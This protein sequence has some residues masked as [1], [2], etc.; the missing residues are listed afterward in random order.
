MTQSDTKGLDAILLAAGR[1][2]RFGG[3]K[4]LAMLDGA[5]LVVHALRTALLAPARRVYVA[6]AD[7]AVRAAVEV[8]ARRL[9]AL[10]RLTFVVVESPEEGMAASLRTAVAALPSDTAGVFVFLGDMP[11]VDPATPALLAQALEGERHIVAPVHLGRR[12]HP[13]LFGAAWLPSLR[14]LSGDQGARTLLESAGAQLARIPVPDA[15]I[16]LDVDHPEDLAR[17][18]KSRGSSA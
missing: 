14:A 12:G 10:K 15:G 11:A 6:A 5:P 18:G 7:P 2:L 8:E 3:G 4:L 9:G 17:A 13:V 16:H 1:G